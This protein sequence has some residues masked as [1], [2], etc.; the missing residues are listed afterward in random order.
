LNDYLD[1]SFK[2]FDKIEL[3][4]RLLNNN[5]NFNS[6]LISLFNDLNNRLNKT[7][8]ILIK[9]K[10]MIN[11]LKN[12]LLKYKN[13]MFRNRFTEKSLELKSNDIYEFVYSVFSQVPQIH[14]NSLKFLR[15]NWY[16]YESKIV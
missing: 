13:K 14:F 1:D 8:E 11:C 4:Y 2:I 16:E 7:N 6:E 9:T 15:N 3:I 5:P 10:N 12:D